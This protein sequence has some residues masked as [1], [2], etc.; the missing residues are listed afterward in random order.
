MR[1]PSLNQ[2]VQ[3]ESSHKTKNSR[4]ANF[5]YINIHV[6]FHFVIHF[7]ENLFDRIVNSAFTSAQILSTG[8][9]QQ[10]KLK[11]R[12]AINTQ[13]NILDKFLRSIFFAHVFRS[14][15]AG[16][17]KQEDLKIRSAFEVSALNFLKM[18]KGFHFSL[19]CNENTYLFRL[20]LSIR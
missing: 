6:S 12:E 1:I 10:T 5:M 13:T 4:N 9:I 2:L 14:K 19:D 18:L 3:S 8:R 17:K 15:L 20:R 16:N 11:L 7:H